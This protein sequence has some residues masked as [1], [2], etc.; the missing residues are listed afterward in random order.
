[1]LLAA[2]SRISTSRLAAVAM[3]VDAPERAARFAASTFVS[4][5]PRPSALPAPPAIASS[6]RIAGRAVADERRRRIAAR[7]RREQSLLVGEQHEHV[8][9]D[10]GS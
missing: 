2:A 1:M 10:R 8:G 5:P 6:A 3:T 9:F 7:I 4:M